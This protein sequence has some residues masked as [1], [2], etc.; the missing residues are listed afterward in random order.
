MLLSLTPYSPCASDS[1]TTSFYYFCC[2]SVCLPLHFFPLPLLSPLLLLLSPYSHQCFSP[3][4][5]CFCLALSPPSTVHLP[6]LLLSAL[7]FFTSLFYLPQYFS[8]NI[9]LTLT[10][11]SSHFSLHII[12]YSML[13]STLLSTFYCTSPHSQLYS[14]HSY[15]LTLLLPLYIHLLL[16][17]CLT[18]FYTSTLSLLLPPL[19]LSYSPLLG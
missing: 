10:S 11:A 18:L 12:P 2:A 4:S 3:F 19:L 14:L 9:S 15:S 1:S 5:L 6:S 7:F 17:F 16:C 13:L 8:A